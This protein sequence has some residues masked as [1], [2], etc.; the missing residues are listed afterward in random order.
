MTEIFDQLSFEFVF[1]IWSVPYFQKTYRQGN[2]KLLKIKYEQILNLMSVW[3]LNIMKVLFKFKLR[4]NPLF[5][6]KV[7][8]VEFH[9]QNI[10]GL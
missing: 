3:A 10:V 9:R 5:S 8:K 1:L 4:S 6:I 2:F 7:T